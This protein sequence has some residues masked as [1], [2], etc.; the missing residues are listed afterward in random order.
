[1]IK[2]YERWLAEGG[3]DLTSPIP[4]EYEEGKAKIFADPEGENWMCEITRSD[5]YADLLDELR[6]AVNAKN[7]NKIRSLLKDARELPIFGLDAS[8]AWRQSI[9]DSPERS[10]DIVEY[11]KHLAIY[12]I[13]KIEIFL[14]W[15]EKN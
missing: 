9:I 5:V 14:D 15:V 13:R 3:R 11:R 12:A 4:F 8:N 10:S 2:L 7:D 6:D 1:M